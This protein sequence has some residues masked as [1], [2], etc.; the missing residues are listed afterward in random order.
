MLPG[1]EYTYTLNYYVKHWSQT[2]TSSQVIKIPSMKISNATLH[3]HYTQNILS[4]PTETLFSI[5]VSFKGFHAKISNSFV[6]TIQST[7]SQN[8]NHHS[9]THI[10]K[11]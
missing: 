8:R 1:V 10:K 4:G 3:H 6:F 7:C 2:V 9:F 11:Y 5:S